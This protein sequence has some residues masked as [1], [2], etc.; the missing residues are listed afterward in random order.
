[1]KEV[2][3]IDLST[4][5]ISISTALAE[6][7]SSLTA[8]ENKLLMYALTFINP[9]KDKHLS[10]FKYDIEDMLSYLEM[11]Y[12]TGPYQ[13]KKVIDGLNKKY[14]A[15][16]NPDK[17][18]FLETNWVTEREWFFE[19]GKVELTFSK[20]LTPH[21]LQLAKG[22]YSSY[23]AKLFQPL[24]GDYSVHL[25][26]ILSQYYH[27]RNGTCTYDVDEL[28]TLGSVSI[29]GGKNGF[30]KPL[31]KYKNYGDF[32]RRQLMPAL[33]EINEKTIK[34]ITYVENKKK[35]TRKVISITFFITEKKLIEESSVID[36]KE[37]EKYNS[38]IKRSE[39]IGM[40]NDIAIELINSFSLEKF[41]ITLDYLKKRMNK[42][43]IDNP[44]AYFKACI[45]K[46][47][48]QSHE[49][50]A[51]EKAVKAEK[52]IKEKS[53]LI[54]KAAEKE[55]NLQ[56]LWIAFEAKLEK[57]ILEIGKQKNRDITLEEREKINVFLKEDMPDIYKKIEAETNPMSLSLLKKTTF[58]SFH[59]K[60][61]KDHVE[62][63]VFHDFLENEKDTENWSNED[64]EFIKSRLISSER[65]K[66]IFND[67]FI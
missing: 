31:R 7:Q 33:K 66:S 58:N 65:F 9:L 17:K 37:T 20:K 49:D 24:K 5:K 6:A 43:K 29:N 41:E 62:K 42:G 25:I 10:S 34:N 67:V 60:V 30:G 64:L 52:E 53:S 59:F 23:L 51:K 21:L 46:E 16:F 4:A 3:K 57:H 63:V 14:V 48:L 61:Y 36:H 35:G 12:K 2:G 39:S 28:K 54:K 13:L 32:K 11:S 27:L 18:S 1:M 55:I 38:L 15:I 45:G 26:R 22:K 19:E 50:I 47:N 8:Q 44:T 56:N 40:K